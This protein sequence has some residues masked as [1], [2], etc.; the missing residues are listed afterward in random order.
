M[1]QPGADALGREPDVEAHLAEGVDPPVHHLAR[2]DVNGGI[3]VGVFAFRTTVRRTV[4]G[5]Q[6]RLAISL[7][8]LRRRLTT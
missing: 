3:E 5:V 6:P 8:G 4:R 7:I 1:D 2:S